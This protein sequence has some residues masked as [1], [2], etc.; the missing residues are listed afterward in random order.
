[1][2][3]NPVTQK[4]THIVVREKRFRHSDH[5]VC[6]DQVVETTPHL[7]RLHCT[8]EELAK[9][10]PFVETHYIQVKRP[11]YEDTPYR[12]WPLAV[13]EVT[14]ILPVEHEHIPPGELAVHRGARVEATDGHVGRLDEFLLEPE[15]G[16]ITHL[17]LREGHL[18]GQKDVTIPVSGIDH[19]EE[20]TVYL[21]LNKHAVESLPA[22]PVRR[23]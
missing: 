2:I 3:I 23:R 19:I 8:K 4:V 1:V 15:T 5:L 10:E 22:V 11:R 17:V 16:Y 6:V 14:M 9:M 21:K 7:V 12:L 20:E 18:W 13:P